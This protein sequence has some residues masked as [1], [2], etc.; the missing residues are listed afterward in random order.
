MIC[1]VLLSVLLTACSLLAVSNG[2]AVRILKAVVMLSLWFCSWAVW[3]LSAF[4][5]AVDDVL[6]RSRCAGHLGKKLAEPGQML[7]ALN[8]PL[9][10]LWLWFAALC[11]LSL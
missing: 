3:L 10:G 5:A 4:T 7:H 8:F 2:G 11:S 6:S 9:I 1:P